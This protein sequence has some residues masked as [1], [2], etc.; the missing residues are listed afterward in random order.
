[1]TNLE[2]TYKVEKNEKYGDYRVVKY[3]NGVWNNERDCNWSK[4][5]AAKIATEYR[6]RLR[7]M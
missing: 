3:V 7:T 1:M 6:K 2:I 4:S 5:K